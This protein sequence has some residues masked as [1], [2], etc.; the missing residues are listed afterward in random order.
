MKFFF[1]LHS[2]R[3]HCRWQL[4]LCYSIWIIEAGSQ[5]WRKNTPWTP[6][7]CQSFLSLFLV[8]CKRHDYPK[9]H[10]ILQGLVHRYQCHLL[11][12]KSGLLVPLGFCYNTVGPLTWGRFSLKGVA[13]RRWWQ[14]VAIIILLN[15]PVRFLLNRQWISKGADSLLPCFLNCCPCFLSGGRGRL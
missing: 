8:T 1:I 5:T 11:D 9:D 15:N 14:T 13:G 10:C 4:L 6:P 12:L 7:A 3:P 2:A